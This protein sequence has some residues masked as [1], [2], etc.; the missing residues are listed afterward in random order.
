MRWLLGFAAAVVSIPVAVWL[1]LGPGGQ[2]PLLG[3]RED[4]RTGTFGMLAWLVSAIVIGAVVQ[5]PVAV[6]RGADVVKGWLVVLGL[7]GFAGVVTLAALAVEPLV[8]EPVPWSVRRSRD[9]ANWYPVAILNIGAGYAVFALAGA[10]F[11][12][13]RRPTPQRR[14]VDGDPPLPS[15]VAALAAAFAIPGAG[16]WGILAGLAAYGASQRDVPWA[17]ENGLPFLLPAAILSTIFILAGLCS[18]V[19][20]REVARARARTPGEIGP[21]GYLKPAAA[22]VGILL[23][24]LAGAQLGHVAHVGVVV[25]VAVLVVLVVLSTLFVKVMAPNAIRFRGRRRPVATRQS[26]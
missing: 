13:G 16:G 26:R 21:G 1:T 17:P 3:L 25:V 23:I 20:K 4:L 22:G 7:L 8:P 6:V 15:L 10:M 18:A 14:V 9:N 19:H 5:T 24:G 2:E 11:W 12:G